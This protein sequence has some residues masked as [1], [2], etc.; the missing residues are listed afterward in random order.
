[1]E[2]QNTLNHECP[3]CGKTAVSGCSSSSMGVI[4]KV[5]LLNPKDIVIENG[6]FVRMKRK[7]GKLKREVV[8]V[9]YNSR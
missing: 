5:Y 7:Y 3:A 2:H 6:V 8:V 9:D 1:M 4:S